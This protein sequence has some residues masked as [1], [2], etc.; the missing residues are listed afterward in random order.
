MGGIAVSFYVLAGDI[1]E[2]LLIPVR[3]RIEYKAAFAPCPSAAVAAAAEVQT[4]LEWYVE[5]GEPRR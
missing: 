2:N 3:F 4:E 1:R 5:P